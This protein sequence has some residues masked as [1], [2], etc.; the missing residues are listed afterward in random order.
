MRYKILR[1][2]NLKA[3]KKFNLV[4]K[5]RRIPP[6]NFSNKSLT[7]KKASSRTLFRFLKR[8]MLI[9]LFRAMNKLHNF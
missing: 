2:P 4:I 8:N 9:C 7:V 3:N 6:K 1:S 5:M